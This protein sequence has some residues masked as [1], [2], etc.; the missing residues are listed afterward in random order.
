MRTHFSGRVFRIDGEAKDGYPDG[1]YYK[2]NR[3]CYNGPF[4]SAEDAAQAYDRSL[5]GGTR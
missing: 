5:L 2:D 4:D 3:M 1:W